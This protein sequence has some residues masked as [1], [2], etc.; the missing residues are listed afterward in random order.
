MSRDDSALS[1]SRFLAGDKDRLGEIDPD[2]E[3]YRSKLQR[4]KIVVI[5][6]TKLP[7]DDPSGHA[8]FANSPEVVRLIGRRLIEGQAIVGT[9]L[10]LGERLLPNPAKRR[11]AQ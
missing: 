4:T 6:L 2:A 11:A 8:K 10:S 5:D 1:L 3:P 7:A 9:D